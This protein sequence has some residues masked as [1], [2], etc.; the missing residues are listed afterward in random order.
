MILSLAENDEWLDCL[1]RDLNPLQ[2]AG[3]GLEHADRQ[4]CRN[5]MFSVDMSLINLVVSA[6]TS[7]R[8][9]SLLQDYFEADLDPKEAKYVLYSTSIRP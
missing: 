5:I 3:L 2:L 9:W 4:V 1:H 7:F 6:P 8:M